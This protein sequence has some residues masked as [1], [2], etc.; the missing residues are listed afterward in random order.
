MAGRNEPRTL[1]F[2]P[3]GAVLAARE[4]D[5]NTIRLWDVATGKTLD[6]LR[7]RADDI[8]MPGVIFS[9]DGR[10]M[11]ITSGNLVRLWSFS[12][13]EAF[14][15]LSGHTD[16]VF[17]IAFSPDNKRLVSGSADQ[18]LKLWD[19]DTGKVRT[20]GGFPV[21]VNSVAFSPDGNKFAGAG[22]GVIRLW[23]TDSGTELKPLRNAGMFPSIAFSPNG[24]MLAAGSFDGAIHI[25]DLDQDMPPV[26]L[27]GYDLPVNR[28]RFSKDG[29]TLVS[30]GD[31]AAPETAIRFWDVESQRETRKLD[32]NNPGTQSLVEAISPDFYQD[33]VRKLTSDGKFRIRKGDNGKLNV[34][35]NSSGKLLVS[36]VALDDAD[37][38]ATTPDGLFDGTPAAWKTI[39]WRFNNNTFKSY[40]RL[41]RCCRTSLYFAL[42]NNE[43]GMS[44]FF[45]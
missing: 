1:V 26:V 2:S 15:T 4:Y 38:L 45:Q 9:S 43:R 22:D 7:G 8:A 14:R 41:Y 35:D 32:W 25:W 36:L 16:L 37:W 28:V 5:D 10:V 34:H 30:R 6:T 21:S 44:S 13:G 33:Y 40:F 18:T 31:F 12:I 29:K 11:A 24:R 42:D 19:L 23:D 17:S 3:N 20:F 27:K 39:L